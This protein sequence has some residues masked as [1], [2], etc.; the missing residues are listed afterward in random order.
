M[1]PAF[2]WI[3][4]LARHVEAKNKDVVVKNALLKMFCK[5]SGGLSSTSVAMIGLKSR[6][7]HSS[8]FLP[9]FNLLHI[10]QG[11]MAHV[12]LQVYL[13]FGGSSW[14]ALTLFLVYLGY[15]NLG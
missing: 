14:T 6:G 2:V 12:T 10:K 1:P 9:W 11:L 15:V 7:S 13:A 5:Q 3:F 4:K 8:S